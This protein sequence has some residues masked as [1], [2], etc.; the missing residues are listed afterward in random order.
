MPRPEE[1]EKSTFNMETRELL[2]YGTS[3]SITSWF[4]YMYAVLSVYVISHPINSQTTFP[5]LNKNPRI[6]RSYI[7]VK[8][9]IFSYVSTPYVCFANVVMTIFVK[10]YQNYHLAIRDSID[11]FHHHNKWTTGVEHNTNLCYHSLLDLTAFN[12]RGEQVRTWSQDR[13]SGLGSPEILVS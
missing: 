11:D 4:G 6:A 13:E 7:R 9:A 3:H 5:V 10:C 2:E 12:T 8:L 1:E